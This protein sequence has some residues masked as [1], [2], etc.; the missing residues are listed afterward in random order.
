MEMA[1]IELFYAARFLLLAGIILTIS[2]AVV[3]IVGNVKYKKNP[4]RKPPT[5]AWLVLFVIGLCLVVIPAAFVIYT[6]LNVI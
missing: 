4:K 5:S 3:R 1:G 6:Y 2:G